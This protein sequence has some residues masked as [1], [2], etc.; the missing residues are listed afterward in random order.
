MLLLCT[1]VLLL[2]RPTRGYNDADWRFTTKYFSSSTESERPA[3]T[4]TPSPGT[5]NLELSL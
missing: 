4:P 2:C 5:A 3:I 1:A